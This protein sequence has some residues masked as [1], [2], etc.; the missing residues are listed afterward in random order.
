MS[1]LLDKFSF[2]KQHGN[3]GQPKGGYLKLEY[4]EGMLI[5][6]DGFKIPQSELNGKF[7][8]LVTYLQKAQLA[9]ASL[10]LWCLPRFEG[11]TDNTPAVEQKEAPYGF[12]KAPVE[13]SHKFDIEIEDF[14]T[15]FYK[16]LRL[17]NGRSDLRAIVLQPNA[18]MFEIDENGDAQGAEVDLT[19]SQVK[20]GNI[21]DY[22][23]Y[24]LNVEFKDKGFF[25]DH[26]R[27]VEI[28]QGKVFRD[29]FKG[30][31]NV[32][33]SEPATNVVK[34]VTSITGTDLYNTY[35]DELAVVGAWVLTNTLT[36][37]ESAPSTVAKNAT[38]KGWT[39]THAIAAP[40]T[41]RLASPSALAALGVGSATSGGFEAQDFLL[42]E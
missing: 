26:L 39:I 31:L 9:D 6:P 21:A 29:Y 3:T 33:I 25:T 1:T 12:K 19:A 11:V 41:I 36:G 14:G 4:M 17:F 24:M 2:S 35:D 15:E 23:K 30:I 42:G 8:D 13:K 16:Q 34:A 7:A 28:P 38:H 10:R 27:S 5:H 18:L 32:S 22:T 40:V 20:I 37:A